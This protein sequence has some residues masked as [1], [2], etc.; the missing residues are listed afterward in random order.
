MAEA[1]KTAAA[2]FNHIFT[3]GKTDLA[4]ARALPADTP[5]AK[6]YRRAE[7]QRIKDCLYAQR[8]AKKHFPNGIEEFDESA[9]DELFRQEDENDE[10]TDAAYKAYYAAKDARDRTEAAALTQ[11]IRQL[12]EQHK[13]IEQAIKEATDKNSIY[14]RVAK[15]YLDAKKLLT[16]AENYSHY[17]EIAAQYEA[18]LQRRQAEEAVEFAQ[19]NSK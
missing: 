16:Q 7:L 2:G 19:A 17:D 1:E 8:V 4:Q 15:P 18:A 3:V 9:F 14:H 6:E 13:Q 11:Q 5:Q 10:Q 12:K